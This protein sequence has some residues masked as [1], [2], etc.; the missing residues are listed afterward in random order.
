M[1]SLTIAATFSSTPA[2]G[3]RM[4]VVNVGAAHSSA[5]GYG[6]AAGGWREAHARVVLDG[7][8]VD[9][10][11]ACGLQ[12]ESVGQTRVSTVEYAAPPGLLEHRRRQLQ[13]RR[14]GEGEHEEHARLLQHAPE[15]APDL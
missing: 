11:R 4:P 8:A 2:S 3:V 10:C 5:P 9:A 12:A 1:R 14:A 15:L 6:V 7:A 13:A